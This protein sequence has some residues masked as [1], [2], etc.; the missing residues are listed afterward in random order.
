[1][2]GIKNNVQ[3]TRKR[4]SDSKKVLMILGLLINT[5]TVRA[6]DTIT[7]TENFGT[8][9]EKKDNVYDI[10]TNKI[11]GENAF[12]S[13]NRFAL[14]EN[15]IANLYFGEKNSTGVNNL[16]NFVNGKIEVD[17]II[18][19]IRENK[20]GGN[21]YFLSSEGMA[22]GKME[23]SMLVLFILLFQNKMILRRLWKKPNM[24]KFLMES[25]Q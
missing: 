23:L 17:G 8:K 3:R 24:V 25:F 1:M 6:N 7:A 16:F 4:I 22:V 2:S 5:M 11:Q 19:G 12:N 10:T 18:N 9:I 20:I 14:T 15:N 13:F 21:L